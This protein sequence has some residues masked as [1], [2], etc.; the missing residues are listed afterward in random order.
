MNVSGSSRGDEPV[1]Q[2]TSRRTSRRR[3]PLRCARAREPALGGHA[4]GSSRSVSSTASAPPPSRFAPCDG[5][6]VTSDLFPASDV[7]H[8]ATCD[9]RTRRPQKAAGPRGAR[10]S[11]RGSE[12]IRL[13]L[14]E[15]LEHFAHD[16]T[17]LTT[18]LQRGVT[19]ARPGEAMDLAFGRAE[20]IRRQLAHGDEAERFGLVGLHGVEV[21]AAHR[22]ASRRSCCRSAR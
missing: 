17:P 3:R 7:A 8:P 19:A 20:L 15:R 16:E 12:A 1:R 18:D 5:S 6:R 9:D 10:E 13:L 22:S 14:A 4:I 2:S 21:P 11:V